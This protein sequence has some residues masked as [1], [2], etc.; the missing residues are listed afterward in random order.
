MTDQHFIDDMRDQAEQD[1]HN[2]QPEPAHHTGEPL[3]D[4][5]F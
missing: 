3:P 2:Y 5:P 4:V 1:T